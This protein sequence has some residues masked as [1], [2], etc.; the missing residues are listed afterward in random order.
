MMVV[1]EKLEIDNRLKAP[2][3]STVDLTGTFAGGSSVMSK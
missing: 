2:L 1:K 3:T